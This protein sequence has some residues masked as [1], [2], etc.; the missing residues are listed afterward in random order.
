MKTLYVETS[1]LLAWLFNEERALEAIEKINL[2]ERIATSA[3]TRLETERALLRAEKT[4]LISAAERQ[5]LLGLFRRVS[6]GWYFL[7]VSNEVLLRAGIEFPI[8]SVRSL[9]AIH[10]ASALES[11]QLFQDVSVLSFDKRITDN[12]MPL[13]LVE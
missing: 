2:A 6:G 5:R 4:G 7:S 9:D 12:L 11:V 3:L 13:G 8:E 10:L 1:A